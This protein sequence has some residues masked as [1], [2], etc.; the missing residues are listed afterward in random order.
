[1]HLGAER[2]RGI[3]E[4]ALRRV[5]PA[6]PLETPLADAVPAE[7][8]DH[9]ELRKALRSLPASQRRVIAARSGLDDGEG[10][11]LAAVGAPLGMC[12]QRVHRHESPALARLRGLLA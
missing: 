5:I 12:R 1:L 2:R 10:R 7:G 6:D 3:V 4:A 8:A 9:P 11:T